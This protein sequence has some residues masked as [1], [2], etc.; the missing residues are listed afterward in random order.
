MAKT[1]Q[2]ALEFMDALVPVATAKAAREAADIQA[3]IDAQKGGFALQPWDWNFYAEQVRKAKYD[4]ERCRD[5]AVL[6]A[7]QRAR[8]RRVLCGHP[9]VRNHNSR[10]ARTSPSISPTCASSRSPTSTAGL[11]RCSIAIISSATTRTAAPGCPSFV[12]PSKLLGDLAVVYNVANLPKPA[13]G[14]PA[15]ISFTDVT[16]MFHEFGHALHGMFAN[17]RYPT[18]SGTTP[19]SGFRRVSVAVQ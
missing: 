2:A 17:T 1:P 18:L 14:E 8:E 4:L 16:T 5:Q 12:R 7:E 13:P 9:A 15:L 11:W 6:R 3:V 10:S 19:A